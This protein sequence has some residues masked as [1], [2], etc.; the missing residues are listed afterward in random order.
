LTLPKRSRGGQ[1][2][3]RNALKHGFYA[4]SFPSAEVR[5]LENTTF[6]GLSE[7]IA[8]LRVYIRRVIERSRGVEDLAQ[9]LA[10]LR[11]ICL[12]TACLNRLL[13]TQQFLASHDDPTRR[14][15][16]AALTQVYAEWGLD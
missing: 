3:N 16:E 1:P 10:I 6:T 13:K 7:E 8:L 14:E 15:L 4:A 9:V 2:G 11:S 5:D 12:A